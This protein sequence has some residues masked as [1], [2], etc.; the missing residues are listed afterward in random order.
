MSDKLWLDVYPQNV[1]QQ[2]DVPHQSLPQM[3]LEKIEKYEQH[4]ALSFQGQEITY[5]QLGAMVTAFASGLQ[6]EGVQ[7]GDRAAIMLPNS[8]Q[9]V[10]AYYGILLAGGIVTQINPMLTE[11]ELTYILN[12][13]GAE[14]IVV[15]DD[16]YHKVKA[17]QNQTKLKNVIVVNLLARVTYNEP[18]YMFDD[19]LDRGAHQVSQVAIDPAEDVAVLQYTGGT[20]GRS[21]G[22]MLTHNNLMANIIQIY[23][24]FNEELS[25]GRERVLTVIPLFHVYG[26]TNGMN[27]AIFLGATNIMLPRFELQDVLET[28]KQSKPT[29]FPGVPTMY[30]GL[31]THP[32]ADKYGLDSIRICNSGSAP[33]PVELMKEFEQKTGAMIAEGYGLSETAP[34]THVN[35]LFAERKT[36]SVGIGLPSTD[37]KIV[38]TNTGQKIINHGDTGEIIIY[39]PQVMK[40]YWNK[41]KET[42]QALRD[43][44]LYTGNIGHMDEEGYLYIVDRKKDMII[45]SGYNVYPREVEEVLYEHSAVLEAA[46]VGVVDDYR[47]ETVKA[48]IVLRE[49]ESTNE[50]EIIAHSRKYLAAYKAPHYVEFREELPK[51]NVGKTLRRS[52]RDEQNQSLAKK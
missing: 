41:P 11:R 10:I 30:I 28:I 48:F 38:D 51:S 32:E 7:K 4:I 6:G 20:T 17:V 21:K 24:I 47:G 12:D 33:M 18:A 34:T 35:P 23:E 39:G 52:L 42:Q 44:W 1:K 49:G 15:Q 22:V 27:L 31:L 26:M 45:A 40:G 14:T 13:S 16:L 43:G 36:G 8:S 19:F 9:Y 37:Y 5:E 50:Q 3:L 2:I 25:F 46:V 29:M